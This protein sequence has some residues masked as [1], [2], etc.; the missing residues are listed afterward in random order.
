MKKLRAKLVVAV[1][2]LAFSTSAY[3]MPE[4]VSDSWYGNMMFRLGVL[5]GNSGFCRAH[6]GAWICPG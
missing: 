3:A 5:S 1:A 2:A 6:P 4:Q